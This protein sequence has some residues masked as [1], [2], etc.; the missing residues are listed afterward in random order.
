MTQSTDEPLSE[1]QRRMLQV[2]RFHI[3]GWTSRRGREA[4]TDLERRGLVLSFVGGDSQCTSVNY[5][6]TEAGKE[7]LSRARV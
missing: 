7:A 1:V 6:V 4:A 2:G 3:D 5:D